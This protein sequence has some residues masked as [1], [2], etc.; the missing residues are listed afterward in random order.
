MSK[1]GDRMGHPLISIVIAS[2]N[3]ASTLQQCLDSIICQRFQDWEIVIMDGAS[4]DSTLDLLR[5]RGAWIN[6][7]QSAKDQGICQAWNRA[8]NHVSGQW[9]LFLGGRRII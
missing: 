3:A 2:R 7:W 4:E 9:I 1:F 5:E 8:L 6:Y